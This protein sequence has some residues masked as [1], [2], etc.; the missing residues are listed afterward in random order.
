[1]VSVERLELWWF[2]SRMG[3]GI[4]FQVVFV[5]WVVLLFL[6]PVDCLRPLRERTRSWGDEV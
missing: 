5:W 6:S 2:E 3:L 4:L 1:M